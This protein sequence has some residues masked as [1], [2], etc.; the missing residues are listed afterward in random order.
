MKLINMIKQAQDQVAI[1]MIQQFINDKVK[2]YKDKIEY[3]EKQ[4]PHWAKGYTSDS[5]AAQ[6]TTIAL[7]E[8]WDLLSVDNQTDAIQQLKDILK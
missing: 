3:L 5:I 2:V 6:T 4:R 1:N 7:Q 8:I